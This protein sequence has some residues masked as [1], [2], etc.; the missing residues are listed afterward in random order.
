MGLMDI[1]GLSSD[2]SSTINQTVTT[3]MVAKAMSTSMMKC[4]RSALL[5]QSLEIVGSGNRV[6]GGQVM[7]FQLDASCLNRAE[8]LMELQ[9]NVKAAIESAA[10]AQNVGLVG[11]LANSSSEVNTTITNE[12]EAII[13]NKTITELVSQVQLAQR[14]AIY[15]DNNIVNFDQKMTADIL[16]QACQDV[17]NKIG[18]VQKIDAQLKAKAESTVDNPFEFL[19]EFGWMSVLVILAVIIMGGLIA[20]ATMKMFRGSDGKQ[21]KELIKDLASI[22]GNRGNAAK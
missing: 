18:A 7:V 5:S 12:V 8:N 3:K 2:S 10:S 1:L 19:T 14:I 15:G 4:G 9:Q 20:L 21:A 22:A 13:D 6:T 16:D 17:V 11:L